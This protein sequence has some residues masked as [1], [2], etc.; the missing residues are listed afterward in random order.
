[1]KRSLRSCITWPLQKNQ[2]EFN[3][4]QAA[5]KENEQSIK[6]IN[7]EYQEGR[8]TW[9]AALNEFSNLPDE[10]FFG[11]MT[12]LIE[13]PAVSGR[14][15]NSSEAYWDLLPHE[16]T[17]VPRWYN[18]VRRGL[19]SPVKYQGHCRSCVVFATISS[20]ETCFKKIRRQHI[21]LSEQHFIECAYDHPGVHG[22]E[23]AYEN[24]YL[25][26]AIENDISAVSERWFPYES[27]RIGQCPGN[28]KPFNPNFRITDHKVIENCDEELM[29]KLVY[30]HGSVIAKF[31]ISQMRHYRGGVFSGC[32]PNRFNNH[33][34]SVV[35]YGR[36]RGKDYWLLK[37]SWGT[38]WGSG[39]Y[40]K[41][42]RGKGM[43]GINKTVIVVK[44]ADTR[45]AKPS[46]R[47]RFDKRQC[48]YN[49]RKKKP[50]PYYMYCIKKCNRRHAKL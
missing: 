36:E 39:G 40:I 29:K 12:G 31:D 37:N 48:R 1:M 15:I 5:L 14:I 3:R 10:E 30:K 42:E 26:W 46:R 49:C 6:Q 43:C 11:D 38:A 8:Q 18:G 44:C 22:C 13:P 23:G 50:Y 32:R 7:K 41:I 24:A 9:F 4:K 35:G 19:V 33:A 17:Y 16:R 21:D 45:P 2:I 28:L 34:G 47:P 27:K 25:T 20:I